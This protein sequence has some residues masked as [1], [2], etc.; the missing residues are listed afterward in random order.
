MGIRCDMATAWGS[1]CKNNAA[2]YIPSLEW[3]V[4][5]THL[6]QLRKEYQHVGLGRVVTLKGKHGG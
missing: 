4:C 6:K 5:A 1:R 2:Y 3:Y